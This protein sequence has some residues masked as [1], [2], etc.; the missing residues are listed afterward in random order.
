MSTDIPYIISIDENGNE[1]YL[2]L[3][4]PQSPQPEEVITDEQKIIRYFTC[5]HRKIN[6]TKIVS[7]KTFGEFCEYHKYEKDFVLDILRKFINGEIKY[8]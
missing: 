4:S 3:C 8:S 7:D 1:C 2:P 5:L 6:L